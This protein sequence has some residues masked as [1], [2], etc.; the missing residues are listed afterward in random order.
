[1]VELQTSVA[2]SLIPR[3]YMSCGL[4]SPVKL[5]HLDFSSWVIDVDSHPLKCVLHS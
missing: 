1:M 5:S 2:I 3:T 4:I